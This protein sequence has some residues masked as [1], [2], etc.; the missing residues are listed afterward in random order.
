MLGKRHSSSQS[1]PP[2]YEKQ[3]FTAPKVCG[4]PSS[5]LQAALLKGLAAAGKFGQLAQGLTSSKAWEE[6]SGL[7]DRIQPWEGAA[8]LSSPLGSFTGHLGQL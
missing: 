4:P 2:G 3:S 5:A 1:P 8:Q 6:G 7:Q